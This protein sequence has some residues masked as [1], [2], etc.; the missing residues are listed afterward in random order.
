MPARRLTGHDRQVLAAPAV[1]GF[2]GLRPAPAGRTIGS[3]AGTHTPMKK[4][5]P[6]MRI[7]LRVRTAVLLAA[8]GSAGRASLTASRPCMQGV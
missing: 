2:G 3:C 4:G 5:L 6:G 7:Q 1:T 8:A